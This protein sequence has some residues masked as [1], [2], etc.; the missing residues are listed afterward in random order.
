MAGASPGFSPAAAREEGGAVEIDR[1]EV[2]GREAE[3]GEAMIAGTG[4]RCESGAS[5]ATFAIPSGRGGEG[6]PSSGDPD[7]ESGPEEVEQGSGMVVALR[8]DHQGGFAHG[9]VLPFA[10]DASFGRR[11]G[12][13]VGFGSGWRDGFAEENAGRGLINQTKRNNL[14][15]Q[16]R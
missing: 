2:V 6:P 3:V 5:V 13:S 11:A 9:M 1:A 7:G 8:G 14:F 16:E 10:D 12:R 15:H 4:D